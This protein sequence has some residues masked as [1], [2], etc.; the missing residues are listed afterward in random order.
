MESRSI[1]PLD[2]NQKLT[3]STRLVFLGRFDCQYTMR[4]KE[5]RLLP[6][7]DCPPPGRSVI[8]AKSLHGGGLRGPPSPPV[9]DRVP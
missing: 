1:L 2:S 7:S 9:A 6:I 4:S 8:T 3:Y 5:K